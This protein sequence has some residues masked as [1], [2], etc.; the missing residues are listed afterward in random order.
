MV[1]PVERSIYFVGGKVYVSFGR[2]FFEVEKMGFIKNKKV[3]AAVL[4]AVSFTFL[5]W[6][7]VIFM[8]EIAVSQH[9][10]A[11]GYNLTPYRTI[12]SNTHDIRKSPRILLY[13]TFFG[14]MGWT[15]GY[16]NSTGNTC[17]VLCT[18]T[19]DKSQVSSADAVVYHLADISWQSTAYLQSGAGAWFS[20]P[21]YR[22]ADQVWVLYNLEPLTMIWG[23]MAAWQGE[24]NWTWSY[25]RAADVVSP[26]GG[27]RFLTDKE[28]EDFRHDSQELNYNYL[29]AKTKDGGVAMISHCTDEARRYKIISTLKRYINVRVVGRCGEGCP[30]G[31]LSCNNLLADY[32]FYLAFENSDCYDYVSEKYWRALERRQ[33]P[34]VAWKLDM[35]D[36]VIPNS[37]I[38]VYDFPDV[39]AAGRYIQVVQGNRTLYN[40]Y[41]EWRKEY[42]VQYTSGMCELCKKL[43]DGNIPRTVYHDME[44]WINNNTCKPVTVRTVIKFTVMT[45]MMMIRVL[46]EV[47]G[48]KVMKATLMITARVTT[49]PNVGIVIRVK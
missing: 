24:F 22:R 1:C 4:F 3:R 14:S 35:S 37:F 48:M 26:Y 49:T 27:K 38:N 12:L 30:D 18:I 23:N 44:G 47:V 19:D 2:I 31:Y 6:C 11:S 32:Q 34:I 33:I 29:G 28:K 20:F 25:N 21:E 41:F 36:L 16:G 13:T 15:K 43:H 46:A 39:D 9:M 8:S 45:M 42:A 7:E 40:S 17:P 10:F 5:I